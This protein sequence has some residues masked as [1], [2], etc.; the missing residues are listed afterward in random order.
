MAENTNLA[1]I[2]QITLPTGTTYQIKDA[3]ARE[4][5]ALL[6]QE[7]TGALVFV[8]ITETKITDGDTTAT[9]KVGGADHEAEIG[10]VVIYGK[11]EF[12][13]T[14]AG[15][16]VE[17]GDFSDLQAQLGDLA[18]LDSASGAYTPSGSVSLVTDNYEVT[19][20]GKAEISGTISQPTFEGEKDQAISVAGTALMVDQIT[21]GF[22]GTE[23]DVSVS[24]SVTA[25]GTVSK[26]SFQGT[27][28]TIT[29]E[30]LYTPEGT[31]TAAPETKDVV[32]TSAGSIE[33]ITGVE[34]TFHGTQGNVKV[35]GS[36]VPLG[37]VSAPKINV[38][39]NTASNTSW[40]GTVSDETL[41]F[42][43]TTI[44]Y[45][46]NVEAALDSAPVFT[47]QNTTVAASGKF[48]PAGTIA[49]TYSAATAAISVTGTVQKVI[50]VGA[51]FNGTE[52]SVSVTATYTPTG[53][54]T[55]PTFTGSAVTVNAGGKFTPEGTVAPSFTTKNQNITASGVFTAKGTV[56]TPTFTGTDAT[57]SVKGTVPTA[58]SASFS[59]DAATITVSAPAV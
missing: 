55:Q 11:K 57:L 25:S 58:K 6:T 26:P 36:C 7:L 44:T 21:A 38:D 50:G 30:G 12:V 18:Y 56:S 13:F 33:Q 20:T 24:G 23:G 8:G 42:S 5:L 41:V 4:E 31:I 37:T 16:W 52:K 27:G 51:T 45:V 29:S 9:I 40:T 3:E 28:A 32:L 49:N 53:E 39:A 43:A 2:S 15:K 35:S 46:D 1:Y 59:G 34:S 54:V 10:D 22:T 17:L 48:T 47:G 19:S 14:S